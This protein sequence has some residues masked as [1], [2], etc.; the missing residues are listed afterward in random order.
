MKQVIL[1]DCIQNEEARLYDFYQKSKVIV[2]DKIDTMGIAKGRVLCV[3]KNYYEQT[4]EDGHIVGLLFHEALHEFLGHVER[5][6]E[7]HEIAN[8]AMD[9][10]IN[11]LIKNIGYTLPNNACTYEL[12]KVPRTLRTTDEIYDY[13]VKNADKKLAKQISDAKRK[14]QEQL[15]EISKDHIEAPDPSGGEKYNILQDV[16]RRNLEIIKNKCALKEKG[17]IIN[18]INK[19]LGSF[20][21]PDFDRTYSRPSRF[22]VQGVVLPASRNLIRKPSISLYLDISGSMEGK[23]IKRVMDFM[24]DI[25]FM[26]KAY[27]VNYYTFNTKSKKVENYNDLKIGGGTCFNQFHSEDNSDVVLIITDCEF[28]FSFLENH[29]RKKLILLTVGDAMEMKSNKYEAFNL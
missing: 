9:I 15:D 3:N 17:N 16:E 8:I 12:F 1:R 14:K 18:S 11:N 20:L 25:N 7:F 13:L 21:K 4:K 5:K 23:N 2:S 27:Q 26:L 22:K 19:I 24:D 28:E 10:V 29:N 6:Y